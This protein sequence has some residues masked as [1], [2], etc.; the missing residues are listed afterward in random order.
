MLRRI[1][2]A[3]S[4]ALLASPALAATYTT[5]PIIEKQPHTMHEASLFVCGSTL[6]RACFRRNGDPTEWEMLIQA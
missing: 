3:S 2:L 1:F 4:V 5:A 6:Y